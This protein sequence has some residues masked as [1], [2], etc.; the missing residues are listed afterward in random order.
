[1]H[2]WLH[3]SRCVS[4][5]KPFATYHHKSAILSP[6]FFTQTVNVLCQNC[7]DFQNTFNFNQRYIELTKHFNSR[8]K[9]PFKTYEYIG[10]VCLKP[11]RI[12]VG[13]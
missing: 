4:P 12:K 8:N 3:G 2:D 7:L 11:G 13:Q 5:D 1:M 9:E 10:S 6:E